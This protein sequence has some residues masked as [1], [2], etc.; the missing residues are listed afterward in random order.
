M[1]TNFL[2]VLHPTGPFH[3][4]AFESIGDRKRFMTFN[5]PA[6]AV[7]RIADANEEKW[8]VYIHI[9]ELRPEVKDRR[10]NG[11]HGDVVASEWL[12]CDIDIP[13]GADSEQIG[14]AKRSIIARRQACDLPEPTM[15]VDSG[16]GIWFFWKIERTTDLGFLEQVNKAIQLAIGI[17]AYVFEA[18]SCGDQTRICRIGGSTNW[19]TAKK[20]ADGRIDKPLSGSFQHFPD[21]KYTLADFPQGVSKTNEPVADVN[22][23]G[24]IKRLA[25]IDALDEWNVPD[26]LKVIAVQGLIPDEPKD[27]DN[28]I[29]RAH[30]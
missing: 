20:M 21:R 6:E 1:K 3:I 7:V 29:G 11:R 22:V 16:H 15:I 9:C 14:L 5:D 27:G 4:A 19:P 24:N 17:E 23:S 2:R 28:K 8:N 12:W 30:V 18:D 13:S 26:S 10:A 25:T